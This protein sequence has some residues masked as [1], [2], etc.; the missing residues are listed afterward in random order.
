MSSYMRF[1]VL[2][3]SADE[4]WLI[5]QTA[6]IYPWFTEFEINHGFHPD[7]YPDQSCRSLFGRN[8]SKNSF[9]TLG[10]LGCYGCQS[11]P[12]TDAANGG[13]HTRSCLKFNFSHRVSQMIYFKLNNV[14]KC[15]C[16]NMVTN[17]PK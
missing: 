17:L 8:S 15:S 5:R 11:Q 10:P 2:A 14:Q 4:P 3:I 13:D 6:D 1:T 12:P 16:Y 7:Q 9:R